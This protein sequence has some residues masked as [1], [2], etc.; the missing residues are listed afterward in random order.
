MNAIQITS[1][2][3]PAVVD[4]PTSKSAANRALIVGSLIQESIIVNDLPFADDVQ[5]LLLILKDIGIDLSYSPDKKTVVINNSFPECEKDSVTP[6]ILSGSEGGT[7]IRFLIPFLALGKNEY[8]IPMKGKLSERPF[9][10]ILDLVESL[11][12]MACIE[13]TI[14]KI[15]GPIKLPKQISVDCSETTQ[16]FSA[17]CLLRAKYHIEVNA[18]NLS[19]S[20]KYIELTNSIINEV[21]EKRVFSVPVDFSSLGYFIA[22]SVVNQNLRISNVKKI[23]HHQA[24]AKFLDLLQLLNIKFSVGSQNGL[25]IFKP[26]DYDG[27][28]VNGSDYIDLVPTLI[29]LASFAK[30]ESQFFGLKP[31]RFKECDRL[32]EMMK[33]LTFFKV[34]FS[35]HRENESLIVYPVKEI[36][37]QKDSN[38]ETA[39]DHRMVMV[40]SLF[41][42]AFGGGVISPKAAV[43]KSF[44]EFFDYF[45]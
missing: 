35:Y 15:K 41:L 2:K 25:E 30:T 10:E 19:F 32:E 40:G 12:G 21:K 44:P 3:L 5:D 24:D 22:F 37:K 8:K 20:E 26:K 45:S 4:C 14:L 43:S 42:K 7:T 13:D 28:S 34:D 17:F 36:N 6:M 23:D 27:F 16:F 33:I 9:S 29:F 11:G 31:L 1:S 38:L 18:K 39:F